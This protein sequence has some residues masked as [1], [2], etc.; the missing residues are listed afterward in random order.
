MLPFP[1]VLAVIPASV[2]RRS[3]TYVV[4]ATMPVM[5]VQFRVALVALAAT[6]AEA[7]SALSKTPLRLKSIHPQSVA[8]LPVVLTTGILLKL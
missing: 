4:P 6:V 7:A 5:F 2:V 1:G 8:V 3:R